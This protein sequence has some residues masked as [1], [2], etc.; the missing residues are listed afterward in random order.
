MRF[1]SLIQEVSLYI[2]GFYF[3]LLRPQIL[4]ILPSSNVIRGWNGVVGYAIVGE[5][6][7]SNAL[8]HAS[9]KSLEVTE[10]IFVGRA[11]F[12]A[13]EGKNA[14]VQNPPDMCWFV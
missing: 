8:L 3:Y 12:D 2:I 4:R 6:N 13:G 1:L 7:L 9:N 10:T 14:V 5:V 11:A